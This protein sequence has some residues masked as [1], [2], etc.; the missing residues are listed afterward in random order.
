MLTLLS[1]YYLFSI[2]AILYY[3]VQCHIL[4]NK[5]TR[6]KAGLLFRMI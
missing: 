1:K 5:K 2:L 3:Y 4:S 6:T